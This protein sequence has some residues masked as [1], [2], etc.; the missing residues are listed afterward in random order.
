MLIIAWTMPVYAKENWMPAVERNG[1][2]YVS[3]RS[4]AR[5]AEIAIKPLPG[6]PRVVACFGDRCA[7]IQDYFE[8]SG[9]TYVAVTALTSGL[10]ATAK[11]NAKEREV[12]FEFKAAPATEARTHMAGVGALAP[13]FRLPKLDGGTV[14]LSDFRGKRVLINSWGSW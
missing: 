12:E 13:N 2:F 3:A 14:A 11:Y 5:T 10:G 9:E 1:R 8:S 6:Q 4:L 7:L